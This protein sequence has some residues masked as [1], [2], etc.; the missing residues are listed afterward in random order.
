MKSDGIK[1][2][3]R[4][5]RYDRSSG[6]APSIGKVAKMPGTGLPKGVRKKKDVSDGGRSNRV[7]QGRRVV[8]I[9][10]TILLVI[11]AVGVLGTAVWLGMGRSGVKGIQ[12]KSYV[13]D[14]AEE[15]SHSALKFTPP[16]EKEALASVKAAMS[17]RDPAKIGEAFRQ[18]AASP[19]AV[20]SFLQSLDSKDGAITGYSYLGDLFLNG[21]EIS[22][23]VVNFNTGERPRNRVAFLTPDAEG[24]W[25]ID[26][27]AFA[28]TAS[29][30]WEEIVGKG[31]AVA[32]VRVY[33]ARDNYYNGVFSNEREWVCY[34]IAS[35][36]TTELFLGYC[37]RGSAQA[38]AM[39]SILGKLTSLSRVTLEFRQ[40][41]GGAERQYE[42]SQ[43]VAQDWVEG[44][45][46]FDAKFQ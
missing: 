16:S 28:R 14:T 18:G 9:I 15:R 2:S 46:P 4:V 38:K 11:V 37:R 22:G 27:D 19:E 26:F 25:K 41:E 33:A 34:G 32:K 10:W 7:R 43:V 31:T 20:V 17:L 8:V 12:V 45:K 1:R 30:S 35:P 40:R 29:P 42:I 3:V 21:L 6:D 44:D 13:D 5:T 36:D 39:E 24:I 23:V